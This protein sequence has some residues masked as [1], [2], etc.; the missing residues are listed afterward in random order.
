MEQRPLLTETDMKRILLE[1]LYASCAL[2]TGRSRLPNDSLRFHNTDYVFEKTQIALIHLPKTGGTSFHRFLANDL[3]NRFV[4]LNVHR[5][6]SEFCSPDRFQYITILRAP[7][8]RVWSYY[9]MVLASEDGYPYKNYAV[10]GLTVFLENCWEA[11]NMA[12]RYY[13]GS[14]VGEPNGSTLET[15]HNHLR[16]FLAVIDFENIQ[17]G[18]KLFTDSLGL[19]LIPFP[20][21]RRVA[22]DAPNLSDRAVIERFNALDAELYIRWQN[23]LP[24]GLIKSDV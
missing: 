12:C 7:V 16:K 6:I 17:S 15:A 13:S 3:R 20:H 4:G 23:E 19:P 18:V 2:L 21:L 22:Y 14:V 9:Q 8:A 5:P 1:W 11:R 24:K 10:K